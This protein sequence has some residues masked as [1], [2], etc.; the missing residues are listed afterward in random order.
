MKLKT[1]IAAVLTLTAVTGAAFAQQA[2]K[3]G[4]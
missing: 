4:K 3:P 1:K 2:L